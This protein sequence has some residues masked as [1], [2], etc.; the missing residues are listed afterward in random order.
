MSVSPI[1]ISAEHWSNT[2]G[3]DI[4]TAEQDLSDRDVVQTWLDRF[5]QAFMSFLAFG[6]VDPVVAQSMGRAQVS[7]QLIHRHFSGVD[8][9]QLRL[10]YLLDRY[11]WGRRR[12]ALKKASSVISYEIG[13]VSHASGLQENEAHLV[14]A[15]EAAAK[16]PRLLALY[17][18]FDRAERVRYREFVLKQGPDRDVVDLG[19]LNRDAVDRT[20]RKFYGVDDAARCV[21][22]LLTAEGSLWLFILRR[23]KR[24]SILTY[25]GYT[26]VSRADWMIV[27]V[28]AEATRLR[29]HDSRDEGVRVV[30]GIFFDLTGFPFVYE[31]LE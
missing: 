2:L 27:E 31:E 22:C 26:H 25:E 29:V 30:E 21:E 8:R 6:H 11:L 19:R 17:A 28:E 24:E 7:Q 10:V 16:A 3:V 18:L 12:E 4:F 5:S 9:G 23:G 1:T 15:M 20:L 13:S 14:I